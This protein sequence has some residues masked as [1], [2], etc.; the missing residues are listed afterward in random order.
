VLLPINVTLAIY[1]G[2]N[3]ASPYP[4]E[5]TSPA[6]AAVRGH[7]RHHVRHGRFGSAAGLHWTHVLH[8]PAGTDIRS[9]YDTQLTAPTPAQADTVVVPDYPAPGWCTAF[10]VVL[11]QR[12]QRGRGDASLRVYVDRLQ[13]RAG[14]CTVPVPGCCPDLPATLHATIPPGSGCPC[15]DGTDVELTFDSGAQAWIGS[16]DVCSGQELSVT[17]ACNGTSCADATLEITFENHGTVEPQLVDAGCSC[18]P[19]EMHFTGIVFPDQGAEC[20]GGIQ[21]IVTE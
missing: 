15:L 17:F 16:V 19:L 11:V 10:V 3:A 4:S 14:G 9:A 18:A 8:L 6:V 13:P 5:G 7:I 1:R 12:V 21:V 2:F 20:D